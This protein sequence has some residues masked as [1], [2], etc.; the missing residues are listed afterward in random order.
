M[1]TFQTR[2]KVFAQGDRV[3]VSGPEAGWRQSS[4]GRIVGEPEPINTLQGADFF[5]WVAFDSPQHDLSED[6][7]YERAQILSCYLEPAPASEGR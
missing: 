5:Y 2:Q 7:P 6:G 1:T 4:A 3:Q